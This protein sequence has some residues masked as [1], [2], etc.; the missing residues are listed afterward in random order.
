[1]KEMKKKKKKPSKSKLF[2]IYGEE[3][4]QGRRRTME[5]AHVAIDEKDYAFFCSL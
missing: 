5:D 3:A 1:M 4:Q 2:Y